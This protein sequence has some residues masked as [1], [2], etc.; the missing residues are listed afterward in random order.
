[1][2][3]ISPI[4][5][6]AIGS[7]LRKTGLALFKFVVGDGGTPRRYRPEAITCVGPDRSGGKSI[8]WIIPSDRNLRP[9]CLNP[10]S[11]YREPF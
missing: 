6:S 2:P 1:M 4:A 3:M 8:C 10:R 7:A 9:P 11:F 5:T